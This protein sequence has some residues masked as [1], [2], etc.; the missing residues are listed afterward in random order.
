MSEFSEFDGADD[1]ADPADL[2]GAEPGDADPDDLGAV[3]LTPE[4]SGNDFVWPD[5]GTDPLWADIAGGGVG[6]DDLAAQDLSD[7][8]SEL[9]L[10]DL[11]TPA[12]E[13]LAAASASVDRMDGEDGGAQG[14][15]DDGLE[16]WLQATPE[17]PDNGDDPAADPQ[18]AGQFEQLLADDLP[19]GG[20]RERLVEDVLRRALGE[21]DG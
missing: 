7:L 11:N 20:D 14:G 12:G 19:E 9:D 15:Y 3:D 10:S 13:D 6:D 17:P 21:P 1:A 16:A 2:H 5:A 8:P 18:F 4:G